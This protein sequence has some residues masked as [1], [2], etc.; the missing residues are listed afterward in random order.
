[1][2]TW[3]L[4]TVK[5]QKTMEDRA[6]KTVREKYLFDSLSFTE[7]EGRCIEEITPFVSGEFEVADIKKAKFSEV[8]LTDDVEADKYYKCKLAFIT[9]DEKSGKEKEH[10]YNI[11]VQAGSFNDAQK[12]LDEWIKGSMT[13][14]RTVSIT[15]TPIMDVF[16]CKLNTEGKD[17]AD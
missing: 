4:C 7:S 10:P 11:L 8:V 17:N 12:R 2:S 14:I 15:E 6:E 3:F 5:L 16:K 1:M 9:L 13:D